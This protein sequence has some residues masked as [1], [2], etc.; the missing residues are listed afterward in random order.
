MPTAACPAYA[1]ACVAVARACPTDRLAAP[2]A[3]EAAPP[4]TLTAVNP[5]PPLSSAGERG[6]R[7][8]RPTMAFSRAVIAALISFR[9][10]E[11][12]DLFLSPGLAGWTMCAGIIRSR[13]SMFGAGSGVVAGKDRGAGGSRRLASAIAERVLARS[14]SQYPMLLSA[15]MAKA[16]PMS[17]GSHSSFL[18][19]S[20]GSSREGACEGASC[21]TSSATGSGSASFGTGDSLMIGGAKNLIRFGFGRGSVTMEEGCGAMPRSGCTTGDRLK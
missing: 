12:K 7:T 8:F 21:S 18:S 15:A 20:N 1:P 10:K 2:P 5:V 14:T 17:H 19:G 11:I 9:T 6:G 16:T 4:A 13:R 3:T